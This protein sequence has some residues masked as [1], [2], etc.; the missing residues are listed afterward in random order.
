MKIDL[1]TTPRL[2]RQ[3]GGLCFLFFAT[4]GFWLLI[5]QGG[6]WRSTGLVL[7]GVIPGMLGWLRPD[8]LRPVFV[9]WMILVFPIG[10]TVSHLL[11]GLL[12]FG[13]FTPVGL[14]LRICGKDSLLLKRPAAGSCWR[15][16]SPVTDLQRYLR[17]Y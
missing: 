8:W 13:V 11:L 5:S 1:Q 15:P 16:K 17:Q 3:F 7:A 10:W 6:S 4:P 9:G 12:F 14:L 2:L